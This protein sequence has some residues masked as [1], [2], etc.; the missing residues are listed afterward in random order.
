M[1]RKQ[2][3]NNTEIS[4]NMH[5][6]NWFS[7]LRIF[8]AVDFSLVQQPRYPKRVTLHSHKSQAKFHKGSHF[9]TTENLDLWY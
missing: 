6:V 7:I 8:K 4:V 3:V 1:K 5:I 9:N 2:V